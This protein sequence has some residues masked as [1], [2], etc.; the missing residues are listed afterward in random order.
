MS[1]AA[2]GLRELHQL[3]I[4][5]REVNETL[6]RGPKQVTARKQFTSRKLQELEAQKEVVMSLKKAIDEKNLQLRSNEARIADLK[7]KLNLAS[8][9]REYDIIRGQIEA[10]TMANSVLEDEIL[11]ALE[12]VDRADSKA[13]QLDDNLAAAMGHEKRIEDEVV[14]SQP[15][16]K[17]EASRLKSAIAEAE[18]P[19]PS[20][21]TE[22]YRRLVHAHGADALASVDAGVCTA[23]YMEVSPQSRVELNSGKIITCKSCA[24]LHYLA[25]NG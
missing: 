21:I 12:K 6:E 19:L 24:R 25:E 23:C 8:S 16:L 14:A 10:D 15:G 11:E 9:N 2:S 1:T 13:A 17:E 7:A 20:A 3:L 22:L 18:N 5:S 4:R